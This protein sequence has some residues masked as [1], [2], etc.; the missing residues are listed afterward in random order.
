MN[1]PKQLWHTISPLF[2]LDVKNILQNN[3]NS[4][5][6]QNGKNRRAIFTIFRHLHL[7]QRKWLYRI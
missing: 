4:T 3:V 7:V 2:G 6:A 1:Q 5:N